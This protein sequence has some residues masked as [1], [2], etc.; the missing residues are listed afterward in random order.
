MERRGYEGYE[1]SP[2]KERFYE[3]PNRKYS[4]YVGYDDIESSARYQY[5]QPETVKNP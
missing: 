2:Q 4:R 5:I 1:Q 3:S